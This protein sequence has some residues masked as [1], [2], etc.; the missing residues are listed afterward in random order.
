MQ[1]NEPWSNNPTSLVH[2][3]QGQHD[4]GSTAKYLVITEWI[5][6]KAQKGHGEGKNY[7]MEEKLFASAFAFSHKC[8]VFLRETLFLR[9]T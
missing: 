1:K 9:G 6:T 3:V 5:F 7:E 8:F 2:D 4:V